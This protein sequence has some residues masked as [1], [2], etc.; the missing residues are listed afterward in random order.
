MMGIGEVGQGRDDVGGA[1][2]FEGVAQAND[3][4]ERGAS[5][6]AEQHRQA[7]RQGLIDSS[8]SHLVFEQRTPVG[9][10]RSRAERCDHVSRSMGANGS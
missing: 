5:E 9:V 1:G 3:T 6:S 10:A 7:G 8:L 2:V 4:V